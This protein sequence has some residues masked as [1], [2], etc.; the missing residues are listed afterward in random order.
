VISHLEC[1]RCGASHDAGRLQSQ[2]P[3]GGP[4]F[5]RYELASVARRRRRGDPGGG[6]RDLWRWREV[7]PIAD[8]EEPLSLGEGG[9]PT[10]ASRA[11]GGSLGLS[12]LWLKDES[13]NP[14]GSFK[15]RGLAVAIHRARALGATRVVIPSAGNAGSATAAYCAR[16]GVACT[17]VMPDSTPAPIVS[18]ARSYGTTIQLVP[19][20]I[21]EAGAWI[22]Q[23][24]LAER[25]FD[26][27]TFKEPYRVEGK[28]TM[29]YELAE[30]F[31]WSLP[32]AIVYPTGGGT[33]LVGLW[34]AFDEMEALGWIGAARP[35][36]IA[37]QAAGCAP[38]V[39]AFESGRGQAEP[40]PEPRTVASGL[41]V[42]SPIGDVLV[43]PIL[44][45]S[46]GTAL[47][48]T[49]GALLAGAR[50]LARE[51]GVLAGPEAGA[52][53]AALSVLLERGVI[54]RDDRVVVF[55]TGA[56][57]KYPAVMEEPAETSR[58]GGP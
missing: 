50:R 39:R 21:A 3:C 40:V 5:A 4:L 49:D 1:S 15:A 17:V 23:R 7:L 35:R 25:W 19:G 42:P 53:V 28:K 38:I 30:T 24:I 20:S 31:G 27:S 45:A 46:G 37:V 47:A 57:W 18:E 51:E 33:G 10:L 26:V 36:M 54:A 52:A 9:T 14:T 16:A 2:C 8:G 48:V 13:A 55:V 22:R 12:Q 58:P 6:R 56:G 32:D 44:R 11:I 34:K 29:G 41:R 43:L